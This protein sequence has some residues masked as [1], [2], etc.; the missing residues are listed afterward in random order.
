MSRARSYIGR[1]GAGHTAGA[2]DAVDVDGAGSNEVQAEHT[3][4][5]DVD[6][7]PRGKQPPRLEVGQFIAPAKALP[8]S[9]A[10]N[11]SVAVSAVLMMTAWTQTA[12]ALFRA[13]SVHTAARSGPPG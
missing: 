3:D 2:S 6:C 4:G 8:P 13:G 1:L 12:E 10:S 5:R 9:V 11:T 7:R